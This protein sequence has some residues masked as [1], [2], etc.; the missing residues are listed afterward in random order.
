MVEKLAQNI[1]SL[2]DGREQLWAAYGLT[3][4]SWQLPTQI[5]LNGPQAAENIPLK[6]PIFGISGCNP[7]DRELSTDLNERRTQRLASAVAKRSTRHW[8]GEGRARGDTYSE[9]TV[10][11]EGGA[12]GDTY[13]EPTVF[14]EGLD[15]NA[16]L[17]LAARFGQRAIFRIDADTVSA[18]DC[19]TG[20]S[21]RA[22]L[23]IWDDWTGPVIATKHSVNPW[24]EA[25]GTRT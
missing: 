19:R 24:P 3:I 8:I 5:V 23:R 10:I 6:W 20:A 9:P 18:I 7:F 25:L 11:G 2:V 1:W 17:G 16:A 21:I 15:Y 22:W 4:L 13:S 14:G 12:D